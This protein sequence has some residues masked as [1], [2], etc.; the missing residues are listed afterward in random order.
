[1]RTCMRKH[2]SSAVE[3]K[4]LLFRCLIYGHVLSVSVIHFTRASCPH[5]CS[6]L[7][8]CDREVDREGSAV[9]LSVRF[10]LRSPFLQ[11]KGRRMN[12]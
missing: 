8:E 1:M 12:E 3:T 6:D 2:Y 4:S 7:Q 5:H 10:V 11:L 9:I